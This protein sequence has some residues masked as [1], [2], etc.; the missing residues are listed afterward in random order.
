MGCEVERRAV[1]R[2]VRRAEELLGEAWEQLLLAEKSDGRAFDPH[3]SRKIFVAD[4][5]CRAA[6]L[7]AC[8]AESLLASGVAAWGALPKNKGVQP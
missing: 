3:P 7:A 2:D 5:A 1:G 8:A 6:R 4:A